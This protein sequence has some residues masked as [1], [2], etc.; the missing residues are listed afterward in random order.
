MNLFQLFKAALMEPK[1]QAAVRILGIGRIMQ[2]IFALILLMTIISFTELAFGF[3]DVTSE[4]EGLLQYIE[5]IRW[6]LYPFAFLFLFVSTTLYHFIKISFFAWAGLGMLRFMK[7]KGE[8][9]HLWRTTALAV[10]VP[11]ILSL[12]ASYIT[13]SLWISM[14][15]AS[16]TILYLYLAV[17][18]YPKLPAAQK[19]RA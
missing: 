8:Y 6:L 13:S 18:F 17:R 11:T 9:R 3:G 10:T 19:K 12:A 4:T 7:R 15:A 16:V 1:K 5:D 14:L 2:Y